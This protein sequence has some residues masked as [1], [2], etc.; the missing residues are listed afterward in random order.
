MHR[1]PRGLLTAALALAA[2]ITAAPS[3]ARAG[4]RNELSIGSWSRALRSPSAN[5]VTGDDLVGGALGYAR[6]LGLRPAPRLALWATGGFTWAGADGEMFQTLETDVL[7][8]GLS[9]G[10]RARYRLLQRAIASARLEAG[11]ARTRLRIEDAMGRAD[12]DARWAATA[13]AAAAIDLLAS[14]GP[15]F[16]FGLRAELGYTAARAPA[17]T[18]TPGGGED[19][20]ILL[21]RRE[22][23]VGHLDLGGPFFGLSLVGRF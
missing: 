1:R 19:G 10:L 3:L 11:W 15:L 5:A 7:V 8:L 13:T 18:V 23:Q 12:A 21:P 6:D 16:G 4:D 14:A 9:A 20:A 17:F 2:A 22:A